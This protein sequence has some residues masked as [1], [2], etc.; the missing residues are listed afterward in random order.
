MCVGGCGIYR[1][2]RGARDGEGWEDDANVGVGK[3]PSNQEANQPASQPARS[4]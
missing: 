4:K 3:K 1:M 2:T